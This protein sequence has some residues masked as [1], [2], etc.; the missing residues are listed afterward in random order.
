M[1]AQ[2]T[3]IGFNVTVNPAPVPPLVLNPAT[4]GQLPNETVGQQL[5]GNNSL[6]T[7]SGGTAPYTVTVVSGGIP[8]GLTL[9]QQTN[10]VT[11]VVTVYLTG[12]PTAAGPA[13][14]TIQVTDSTP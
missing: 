4:G 12:T 5:P 9:T 8:A 1:S 10:Q 14:F 7:I 2:Q 3:S 11:G 13:L 6:F